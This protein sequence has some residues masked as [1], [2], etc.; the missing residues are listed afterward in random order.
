MDSE[1]NNDISSLFPEPRKLNQHVRYIERSSTELHIDLDVI[2][3]V[4]LF[5][6]SYELGEQIGKGGFGK[7][8]EA[9]QIETGKSVVIK[10]VDSDRVPCWCRLDGIMVPMEVILLKKLSKVDGVSKMLEVYDLNGTWEIVMA[11]NPPNTLDL[12]DYICKRGYLTEGESAFIMYQLVGILLQCHAAGVIHRDLKDENILID[13]ETFKICLIDFGSGSF[14]HEAIYTDFDGTRVYS[15][16]EWIETGEYFGKAAEVWTVG[17]LLFDM[18]NGDIPFNSDSE[19]LSGQVRFRRSVVSQEDPEERPSLVQILQ[20]SWM[21]MFKKSIAKVDCQ[22][23]KYA[24]S[25]TNEPVRSPLTSSITIRSGL[26][27]LANL[28]IAADSRKHIQNK[29]KESCE[30]S[31]DLLPVQSAESVSANYNHNGC[32]YGGLLRSQLE[33]SIYKHSSSSY[34]VSNDDRNPRSTAFRLNPAV[35]EVLHRYDTRLP[36]TVEANFFRRQQEVEQQR[37]FSL[38]IARDFQL[39]GESHSPNSSGY[40]SRSS[41]IEERDRGTS[42]VTHSNP[43]LYREESADSSLS[44]SDQYPYV[45]ED[46]DRVILFTI[47]ETCPRIIGES[48]LVHVQ[49]CGSQMPPC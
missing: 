15:P 22:A 12:F 29:Q 28:S 47:A 36:N 5:E 42:K 35:P 8:N 30:I 14:L 24:L 46:G 21:K 32:T 34:S 27:N 13:P 20:H 11:G 39:S 26:C 43:K 4:E 49:S 10:Q 41:S 33:S 23:S 17:I 31:P 3:D 19:I 16:P 9:I 38:D 48:K 18:I 37:Q 6:R 1:N 25:A 45:S 7:V 2:G 44:A 40:I